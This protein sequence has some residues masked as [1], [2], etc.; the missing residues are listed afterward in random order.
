MHTW[1]ALTIAFQVTET[2][3]ELVPLLGT[4]AGNSWPSLPDRHL[5]KGQGSS[6]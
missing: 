1:Q 4:S 2:N 6:I 3:P 5:V